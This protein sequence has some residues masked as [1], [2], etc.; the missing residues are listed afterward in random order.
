MLENEPKAA[1]WRMYERGLV[2]S[3]PGR[4]AGDSW[5]KAG[6]R[7][8]PPAA[9]AHYYSRSCVENGDVPDLQGN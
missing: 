4:D 3:V 2:D 7:H 6:S 5:Q 9:P 1:K 8:R